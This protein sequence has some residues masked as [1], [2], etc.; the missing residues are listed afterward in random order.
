MAESGREFGAKPTTHFR[1]YHKFC[2]LN[3][4]ALGEVSILVDPKTHSR[5]AQRQRAVASAAEVRDSSL[6]TE[7]RLRLSHPHIVALLD[8]TVESQRSLCSQIWTISHYY[9]YPS[10]TLHTGMQQRTS[11][12]HSALTHILYQQLSA[13]S[14][15]AEQGV[16][17][18]VVTPDHISWDTPTS[19]L[20]L[21]ESDLQP[22][23]ENPVGQRERFHQG[24]AFTASPNLF[25]SL[26]K[27]APQQHFDAQKESVFCLGL[28][29]LATATGLAPQ[30]FYLPNFT[31]NTSL[32]E[33]AR[34]DFANKFAEV[35]LLLTSTVEAMTE[36]Q[37]EERPTFAQLLDVMPAY[38]SVKNFLTEES[39]VQ[40]HTGGSDAKLSHCQVEDPERGS[41]RS[42]TFPRLSHYVYHQNNPSNPTK[43]S[44]PYELKAG[45]KEAQ[46][47]YPTFLTALSDFGS[48]K[49]PSFTKDSSKNG[50]PTIAMPSAFP[51]HFVHE[52]KE[53]LISTTAPTTSYSGKAG[54]RVDT[55][56]HNR[57]QP[58]FGGEGKSPHLRNTQ[59]ET[60]YVHAKAEP[61]PV[62]KACYAYEP[63]VNLQSSQLLG[64]LSKSE[65][66]RRN[67]GREEFFFPRRVE[68]TEK[69][70]S[71]PSSNDP[72]VQPQPQKETKSTKEEGRKR[73]ASI[74]KEIEKQNELL[75]KISLSTFSTPRNTHRHSVTEGRPHSYVDE[76][77]MIVGRKPPPVDIQRP[78]QQF[79]SPSTHHPIPQL[80][81]KAL[82]SALLPRVTNRRRNP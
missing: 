33:K 10:H 3:D 68:L 73:L 4:A 69:T 1:A 72:R 19:K 11:F 51:H 7:F 70:V 55:P 2:T 47:A 50:Q 35:N 5:V 54:S 49:T 26:Q 45:A 37:E 31:F 32:L 18:L 24:R 30:Q 80:R 25:H 43:E 46:F 58:T 82:D 16:A 48:F 60:G 64:G 28:T 36:V 6:K 52:I 42:P 22:K 56:S 20:I 15:L 17:A 63:G 38:D 39:G 40:A 8:Y 76:Y 78:S 27:S 66:T 67:D 59:K 81:L 75:D 9:E 44:K 74:A 65:V 41:V 77:H 34:G 21:T 14:F 12:S 23:D 79:S 62:Y 61:T 53:S 71:H 13:H 29:L 57:L